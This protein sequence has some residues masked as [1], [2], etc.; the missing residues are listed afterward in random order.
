MNTVS[1]NFFED[2][3]D[4]LKANYP[5]IY[6]STTEYNRTLQYVR[7]IAHVND[8][9]FYAWDCVNGLEKHEKINKEITVSTVEKYDDKDILEHIIRNPENNEREVYF[10]EDYHKYFRDNNRVV[11]LRKIAEKMKFYDTQPVQSIHKRSK[12]PII[13]GGNDDTGGDPKCLFF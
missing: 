2:L 11:M 4:M 10:L 13:A 9:K 1:R 8:F 6:L 12:L 5:L 3:K 7:N